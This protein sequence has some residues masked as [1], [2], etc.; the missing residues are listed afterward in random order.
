MKSTNIGHIFKD[1]EESADCSVDVGKI[2][3]GGEFGAV[4]LQLAGTGYKKRNVGGVGQ[5]LPS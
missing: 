2:Y 1:S 5:F 3:L 4:S